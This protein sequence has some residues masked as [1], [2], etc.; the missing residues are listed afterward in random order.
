MLLSVTYSRQER[1]IRNSTE[2][3]NTT[4]LIEKN[5]RLLRKIKDLE[6]A[7]K[8]FEER[9]KD[10]SEENQKLVGINT[11]CRNFHKCFFYWEGKLP[12]WKPNDFPLVDCILPLHRHLNAL[13][14]VLSAFWVSVIKNYTGDSGG[15]RTH[16]L[17][18]T[19]AD[20][21]T[22]RPL[23]LPN[24]NW[25]ASILYIYQSIIPFHS[26]SHD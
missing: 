5:K 9:N 4:P 26:H 10:L 2:A 22:S 8:K 24:D 23:S 14:C 21:L 3:R 12:S 6:Q 19:S 11:C 1:K 16:I 25:P 17:L 13:H 20:I 15:I 7:K 18:L